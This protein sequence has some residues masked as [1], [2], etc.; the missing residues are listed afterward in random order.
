M[1]L[2]D[3]WLS[4]GFRFRLGWTEDGMDRIWMLVLRRCEDG[5]VTNAWVVVVVVGPRCSTSTN[6]KVPNNRFLI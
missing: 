1:V 6:A 4:F 5:D 2:S 3:S